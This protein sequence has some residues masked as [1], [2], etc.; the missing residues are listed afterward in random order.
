MMKKD[1]PLGRN[2][3]II[4][5]DDHPIY[6]EG[7][8]LLIEMEHIGQVIAEAG[9]GKDFL[10]LLEYLAPDIVIMDIDMPIIDGIQATQKALEL[11][12]EIKIL[13]LSM[14]GDNKYYTRFIDAGAKGFILKTAGKEELES[15]IRKIIN[16]GS[17]F[18][19][20]LLLNI[21]N[22]LK[23]PTQKSK[24]EQS[25]DL[26]DREKEI[27]QLMC[28]GLS[29]NEIAEKIFL[30]SKTI[31]GYRTKLLLKTETKNTLGLVLFAIKNK[32]VTE[33]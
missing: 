8:K 23:V 18:S 9:N 15:A 28:K 16:G 26:T 32:L 4:L 19:Q 20:D 17:Y 3:K 12:P 5:V 14:H 2:C 24:L 30:S 13:I 10:D 7:I 25:L 6:R 1:L 31:E 33:F 27:M 21:I 11:H 29:S 22:D